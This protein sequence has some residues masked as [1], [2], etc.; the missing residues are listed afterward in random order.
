MAS[1]RLPSNL[2]Q[3]RRPVEGETLHKASAP[4]VSTATITTILLRMCYSTARSFRHHL[5][6]PEAVLLNGITPGRV[7]GPALFLLNEQRRVSP[8]LGL[9]R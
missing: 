4:A 9:L 3:H 1:W 5:A 6:V 7:P 2:V 8:E